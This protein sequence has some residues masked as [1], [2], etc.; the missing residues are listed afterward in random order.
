MTD[1][2]NILCCTD[3]NFVIPMGV[4]I[5]SVCTNDD[6]H[7]LHFHVFIDD[8]VTEAQRT[9]LRQVIRPAD[10][11][12]FYKVDIKNI[13]KYLVVKVANFPVSIYYRLLLAD[14]LPS[15]LHKILYLDADIVVRHDLSDLW[16]TDLT[17]KALAAVSD[18]YAP[19]GVCRRLGYPIEKGYF[20]SG[21]ILFNLDYFRLHGITDKLISFIKTHPEQLGCPDQDTL[22]AVLHNEKIDLPII[23]NVQEG[24]YR[25]P[26]TIVM[27]EELNKAIHDPYIV[28]FSTNNKP[29]NKHCRHPLRNL[30]YEYRKGT[31]WENS[32]FMEH[33][34][35]KR[36]IS[37]RQHFNTCVMKMLNKVLGRTPKTE[38]YNIQLN[39]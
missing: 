11:I 15:D 17:G 22:N 29:W 32:T 20:N 26:P 6:G 39:H 14:I 19:D 12:I 5:H 34:R 30:Y 31:P 10:E 16:N 4:M 33:F 18:Q 37:L 24:Y 35:H 1:I 36:V 13:Q 2:M 3:H 7:N 21:V 38:Y 25:I 27:T 9:E 8:S 28:H 23:Y